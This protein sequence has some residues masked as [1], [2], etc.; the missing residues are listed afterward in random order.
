MTFVGE[1]VE[2]L[3]HGKGSMYMKNGDYF[4]GRWERG[5][6]NGPVVYNFAAESPWNDPAY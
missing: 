3:K 1:W 2:G 5:K 4:E 6:L